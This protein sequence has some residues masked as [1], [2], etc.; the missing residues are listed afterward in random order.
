MLS[1]FEFCV[2]Y[3]LYTI[4]YYL[5]L[6]HIEYISLGETSRICPLKYDL[7]CSNHLR[8]RNRCRGKTQS[9]IITTLRS[10]LVVSP[11]LEPQYTGEKKTCRQFI[12]ITGLLSRSS[13]FCVK[14]HGL[15]W[16]TPE[17]GLSAGK[18]I[19]YYT[20]FIATIYI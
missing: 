8:K 11:R 7:N 13:H 2:N 9:I 19:H 14:D 5:Y 17:N 18:I 16:C 10:R 1:W 4:H 20:V 3:Y 15:S 6:K 12:W